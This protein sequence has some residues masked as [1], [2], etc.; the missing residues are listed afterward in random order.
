[1]TVVS[2]LE[3]MWEAWAQAGI[4]LRDDEWHAP[5]RL[6]GWSVADLYAHH[7]AFP[8]ALLQICDAP[9][10][11]GP[12]THTDAA[13]LLAMFNVPGGPSTSMAGMVRD[14]AVEL[15]RQHP[16]AELVDRF[17]KVAPRA[18]AQ[19]SGI[20]AQQPVSYAGVAVLPLGEAL[21][22]ALMESVVHYLDLADAADLPVPGPAVGGPLRE[23]TNL[24]A[25][26]ADPVAFVERATGRSAADVLPVLR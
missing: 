2:C 25:A 3:L 23:T 11:D 13:A 9:P 21:R 16:R 5:T 7:S 24:L 4:S 14:R 18:L 15:A 12:L 19:A 20:D 26:V 10:A 17:A 8:V 1:M 22:I 6:P